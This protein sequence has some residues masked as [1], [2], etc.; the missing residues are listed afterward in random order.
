MRAATLRFGQT[1]I[2]GTSL[3]AIAGD[4][5]V[6]FATV[7]HHFGNK[8]GLY[9]RCL[10]EG[11]AQLASLPEAMLTGLGE[12]DDEARLRRLVAIALEAS[13]SRRDVSRFLLRATLYETEGPSRPRIERA[14]VSF[15]DVG[16]QVL[17]AA[18]G[19]PPTSLRLP[20]QGLMIL[21]T[22]LAV[23][24]EPQR[25]SLAASD[26]EIERYVGDVAVATLLGDPDDDVP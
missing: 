15:L 14:Q 20:L 6:T 18:L 19:R 4:V 17:G 25:A 8:A 11:Y 16:S 3:R 21:L 1:G 23:M 26:A 12:G 9:D 5:G 13:L 22:R 10:E 2:A 24:D 7:H